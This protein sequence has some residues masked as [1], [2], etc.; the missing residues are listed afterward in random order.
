MNNNITTASKQWMGTNKE[1]DVSKCFAWAIAWGQVNQGLI[2]RIFSE[3]AEIPRVA[4]RQGQ[5]QQLLKT[6]VILIL[7][8]T[9][10]HCNYLLIKEGKI[11]EFLN[12]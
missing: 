2:P 3:V 10:I 12:A 6:R 4:W 9:R 7:N 5:L 8:F 1:R 11:T